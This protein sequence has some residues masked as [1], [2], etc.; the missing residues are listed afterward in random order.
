MY[1]LKQYFLPRF[2]ATNAN[3][4]KKPSINGTTVAGYKKTSN[5]GTAL[6]TGHKKPS[7]NGTVTAVGEKKKPSDNST[8]TAASEKEKPSDNSTVTAATVGKQQPDDTA[9]TGKP[10]VAGEDP[11]LFGVLITHQ[12]A[13]QLKFPGS[14]RFNVSLSVLLEV[15]ASRMPWMLV[16]R[17]NNSVQFSAYRATPAPPKAETTRQR[18]LAADFLGDNVAREFV[19]RYRPTATARRERSND[20]VV[21][22]AVSAAGGY[23]YAGGYGRAQERDVHVAV[24][25]SAPSTPRPVERDDRNTLGLPN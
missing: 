5:N 8:V 11:N 22:S 12:S 10:E 6:A 15:T 9:P 17:R 4:S 2:V 1:K 13:A 23:S 25:A 7:N 3:R 24:Y 16:L 19:V 18:R 14:L 21:V 20:D